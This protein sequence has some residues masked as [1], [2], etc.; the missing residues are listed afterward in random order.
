MM[1]D[2]AEPAASAEDLPPPSATRADPP[3][4]VS[5][6]PRME[7]LREL[8]FGSVVRDFD[9][10][11]QELRHYVQQ[12]LSALAQRSDRQLQELEV[13]VLEQAERMQAQLHQEADNRA[14]AID[15]VQARWQQA[16]RTQRT[17]INAALQR[18][19]HDAQA[20]DAR[21]RAALADQRQAQHEAVAG[22][23]QALADAHGAL[24]A[25]KLARHDLA[26]L[27]AELA[28]RLRDPGAALG[29]G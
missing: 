15:D 12:E 27:L 6:D 13:R 3:S 7:Q 18:H 20:A 28:L 26:D 4:S 25:Q 17:E 8:M 16:S 22:V 14:N 19:E 21:H 29:E 24:Q 9:A 11:L 2:R 23:R 5:A 10:R 1:P